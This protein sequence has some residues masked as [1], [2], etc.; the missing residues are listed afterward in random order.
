MISDDELNKLEEVLKQ[1]NAM[2]RTVLYNCTSNYPC[3]FEDLTLR[4]LP[5]VR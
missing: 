5:F 2:S 3:P 1:N 4:T